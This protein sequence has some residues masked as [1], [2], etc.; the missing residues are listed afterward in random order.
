[1]DTIRVLRVLEYTGDRKTVEEQIALSI[2]GERTYQK[3]DGGLVT[4]R[5]ATIGIY[6]EILQPNGE[7]PSAINT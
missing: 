4:I 5:A 1:M 6:P 3:R 2:H 7:E